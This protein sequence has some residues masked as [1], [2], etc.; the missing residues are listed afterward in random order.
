[1][2][3]ARLEVGIALIFW[4][5]VLGGG[6][7]SVFG[8]PLADRTVVVMSTAG[9]GSGVILDSRTV[10]TAQHVVLAPLAIGDPN[11]VVRD[12]AGHEHAVVGCILDLYCD[13]AILFVSPRLTC[14][15]ALKLSHSASLVGDSIL[16]FGT[17]YLPEWLPCT[18]YGCIVQ[19]KVAVPSIW[20][21][22]TII[23]AHIGPGCSG[24]GVFL[25]GELYGIC[26][27]AVGDLGIVL[28][29]SELYD[30]LHR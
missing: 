20:P 10:L 1:M 18:F 24:G 27:G 25:R 13:A 9:H 29:V 30:L 17:P 14:R 23:D 28:P 12:T 26:V 22:T 8:R 2:K 16:C 7:G 11:F 6:A 19:T 5:L 4:A 3:T 15:G 21:Q